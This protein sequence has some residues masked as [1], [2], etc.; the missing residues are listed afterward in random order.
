MVQFWIP[1][2][3]FPNLSTP[4]N[5]LRDK[6]LLRRF[7]G[8]ESPQQGQQLPFS[9]C[10]NPFDLPIAS[11]HILRKLGLAHT[12]FASAAALFCLSQHLN[13]KTP[14]VRTATTLSRL[15]QRQCAA[16]EDID[17]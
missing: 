12:F 14:Q 7:I 17:S 16:I 10:K 4:Y 6:P 1:V 15:Q 9:T 8:R 5:H 13:E 11:L 2:W 3:I